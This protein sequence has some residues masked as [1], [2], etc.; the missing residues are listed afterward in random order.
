MRTASTR[1]PVREHGRRKALRLWPRLPW[2]PAGLLQ[3]PLRRTRPISRQLEEGH[4][5]AQR[6]LALRVAAIVGQAVGGGVAGAIVTFVV[7]LIKNAM[8]GQPAR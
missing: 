4:D 6:D 7:G 5:K 1:A 3:Q 8:A 2:L